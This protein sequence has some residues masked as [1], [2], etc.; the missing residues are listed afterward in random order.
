MYNIHKTIQYASLLHF[1]NIQQKKDTKKSREPTVLLSTQNK[2][3]GVRQCQQ[4]YPIVKK[5]N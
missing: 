3:K 2:L 5:M 4:H 1:V